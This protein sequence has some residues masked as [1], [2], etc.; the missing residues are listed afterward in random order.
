[1]R[2]N[3]AG[4]LHINSP[5]RSVPQKHYVA[6]VMRDIGGTVAG[7]TALE[8][9]CGRGWGAEI[10]LDRF[11]ATSVTAVDLDPAMILQANAR[12]ADRPGV[13]VVQA[14]ARHLPFP[15]DSFDAVFDFGAIQQMHA[16]QAAIAEVARVLR[17][18]GRFFFEELALRR[19]RAAL[20]LVT[21]PGTDPRLNGFDRRSLLST[22]TRVGLDVGTDYT[23]PR[24]LP[25][26]TGVGDLIGVARKLPSGSSPRTATL[27]AGDLA[28]LE[29]QARGLTDEASAKRLGVSGRTFRRRL[30]VAMDKLGAQSRFEAGQRYQQYQSSPDHPLPLRDAA[31]QTKTGDHP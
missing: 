13:C 30:R 21:E 3:W 10:I 25:F 22:F 17:E 12:L 8:V 19:T 16:W 7:G 14:D 2:L 11:W 28:V 9:G 23:T 5:I 24:L 27:D 20:H 4:K 18:D 1:M 6:R 15:D 29:L 31:R 26:T